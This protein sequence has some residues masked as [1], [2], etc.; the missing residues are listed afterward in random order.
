MAGYPRITVLVVG[1]ASVELD[2]RRRVNHR[3]GDD[4]LVAIVVRCDS[5]LG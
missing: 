3:R 4:S 5:F 1:I 2:C